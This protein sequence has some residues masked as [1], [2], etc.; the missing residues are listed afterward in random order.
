MG[1][2][3]DWLGGKI[4]F[5]ECYGMLLTGSNDTYVNLEADRL[6]TYLRD[7]ISVDENEFRAITMECSKYFSH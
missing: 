4:G 7:S 2:A 5:I 6:R 3:P 1:K